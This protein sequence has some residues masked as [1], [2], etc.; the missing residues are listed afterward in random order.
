MRIGEVAEQLGCSVATLRFYERRG[1]MAPSHRT[2]ANYRVYGREAL[3]RAGFIRR[4]RTL[5]M[6][7]DE[8]KALLALQDQ[9]DTDCRAAH[10]VIAEHLG[11]VADRMAELASLEKD[12]RQIQAQCDQ[13]RSGSDCASLASL[14]DTSPGEVNDPECNIAGVHDNLHQ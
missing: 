6:T 9:P 12:L 8:I 10:A 14:R 3:E 2:D 1:L 5:G 13:A 7:M 4:C 11:H